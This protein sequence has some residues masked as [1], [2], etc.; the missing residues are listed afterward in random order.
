MNLLRT[1][2][3]SIIIVG[4]ASCTMVKNPQSANFQRVKYNS[5]LKLAKQDNPTKLKPQ[6]I[7]SLEST[8][9]ESKSFSSLETYKLESPQ[10]IRSELRL[11]TETSVPTDLLA[12]ENSADK[13]V[14][15]KPNRDYQWDPLNGVS[16]FNEDSSEALNSMASD[17]SDG[18]WG[19]LLY[20]LV[21]VILV[22][23]IIS[24]IANLAGGLIGALIAILLILLIL[25][26]LGYV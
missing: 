15:V 18:D 1:L 16:N 3:I 12:N 23:I 26:I 19:N 7:A 14:D 17:L 10:P 13:E 4:L 20:L 2:F 11:K 24:L 9:L 22:L 5:H 25:R 6:A 8:Q 21:A